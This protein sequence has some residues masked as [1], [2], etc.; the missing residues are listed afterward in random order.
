[1]GAV[2]AIDDAIGRIFI[3][4]PN[5]IGDAVMATPA[6][7]ALRSTFPQ[8]TLV[9]AAPPRVADLFHHH[10]CCDA[11]MVFDKARNHRGI[12]GLLRFTSEV[13]RQRFDL[14]ILLQNAFEAGI[15]AWLSRIPLRAGYRSDHRG[16]LLTHPVAVG[17][18]QRELHHTRYY[19]HMLEALGIR[20]GDGRLRLQLTVQEQSWAQ[21]VLE[22]GDWLAINP[23][24]AYGSA[25]RWFPQRFAAVADHLAAKWRAR[26]VLTGSEAE[27][28]IGREIER[29]MRTQ[30]LN[31][32]GRTTLRQLMAILAQCRLLITNDSGPM[33]LAAALGTPLVAIFGPT[34]HTTTSPLTPACRIVRQELPCAPCLLRHCPTDHRCMDRITVQDV[35]SAADELLR[36]LPP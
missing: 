33:H 17:K 28:G 5:W 27:I 36:G 10:P 24:A 9:V 6:L 12:G 19:L 1:M 2:A 30:P 25:K 16:A 20:G 15:I 3:R 7:G 11:V 23:G 21:T 22:A 4:A 31:L 18:A 34:D 32:I 13:R 35:V 8:A 14:A 26:V 29:A